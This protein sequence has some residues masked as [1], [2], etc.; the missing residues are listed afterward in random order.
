MQH[1]K[2]RARQT[3]PSKPSLKHAR[4]YTLILDEDIIANALTERLE[5]ISGFRVCNGLYGSNG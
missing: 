2:T 5:P 3:R 1:G 4:N